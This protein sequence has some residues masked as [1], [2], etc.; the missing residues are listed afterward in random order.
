[1][2]ETTKPEGTFSPYRRQDALARL[3]STSTVEVT[4]E[5]TSL[6][7]FVQDEIDMALNYDISTEETR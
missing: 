5:P 3:A 4:A 7:Q 2:F 6:G 1:M